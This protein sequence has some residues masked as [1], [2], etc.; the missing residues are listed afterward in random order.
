MVKDNVD[1]IHQLRKR[2]EIGILPPLLLKFDPIQGF[3]VEAAQ[4][5]A[6]LTLLCE[7]AGEVRTFRQCLFEKNDSM[8]ELLDTG[9]SET[10]L[11]I[12]P[13][14]YCNVGRFFN[15]INKGNK[16]SKRRQNIRSIRC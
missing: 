11:V 9:D 14:K 1:V 6:D 4:D 13:K 2:E 15:S 8:M 12:A 10:S 5:L 3:Y 7:Y 16:E